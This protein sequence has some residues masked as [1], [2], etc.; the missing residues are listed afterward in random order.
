MVLE[1]TRSEALINNTRKLLAFPFLELL[2]LSD[3]LLKFLGSK[4]NLL[5]SE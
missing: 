1:R 2:K 5:K 4:R 3:F